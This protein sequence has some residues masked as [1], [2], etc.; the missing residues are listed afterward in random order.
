ML[1]GQTGEQGTR[2]AD[3]LN[4]ESRVWATVKRLTS[5]WLITASGGMAFGL[6]ATLIA[7]TIMNQI[8]RWIGGSPL[9]I[10][11]QVSGIAAQLLMG[12]GIGAGVANSLKADRLVLFSALCAGFI[13][14]QSGAIIS[15]V[16]AAD[17]LVALA[18]FDFAAN[19]AVENGELIRRGGL[20]GPGE[21][22]SALITSIVAVEIGQLLKGRSKVDIVV[23]PA[24]SILVGLLLSFTINPPIAQAFI[25]FGHWIM[26]STEVNPV[27]M[28]FVLAV[29]VGLFLTMPTSSAA[30]CVAA[31]IGG[32]AGGAAVVGGAAHMICFAV[33]SWRENRVAGLVAQGLGTSMLQIPNIFRNPRVL[34]P[35]VLAS[36]VVGPLAAAVFALH[37]ASTGSG[38]GTAG[39]VGLF[40]TVSS[41]LDA[42]LDVNRLVPGLILLFFVIPALF[43]VIGRSVLGKIGWIKDG[44][45]KLD[46]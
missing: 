21:P 8:G 32:L 46:L 31:G 18:M 12:A 42:G 9:G 29:S 19:V 1:N 22:V 4:P 37:C 3:S 28:G 10:A 17:G 43:G 24:S 34:I 26:L 41:S 2:K 38:M 20:I 13:G 14:A 5:R 16:Q 45:L 44:D 40:T 27:W 25:S 15:A 11:F 35:P 30:I 33:M 23:L 6:F 7:G 39:L 36:A